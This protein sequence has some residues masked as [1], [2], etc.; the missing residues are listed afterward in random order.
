MKIGMVQM[1]TQSKKEENLDCGVKM[2]DH[3]AKQKVDLVVFPEF[4]NFLGPEK[5]MVKQGEVLENSPSLQQMAD[6]ARQHKLHVHIGSILERS[7]E[8]SYNTSVVLSPE[9][10]ILAQYRKIHLFDVEIPGGRRYLESDIITPGEEV[11]TF[12]IQG[13]TF[14]M[15]TCYDL[16]F[17]EMFRKLVELG[18]QVF[19]LP[20]AFTMET[21]RDHWELLLRARAVENLCWVVGVN[22]WGKFEPNHNSYGRSMAVDPWGVVVCRA[23]D[24]VQSL[25]VEID[26]ELLRG[27]RERFP[28]LD[29]IRREI[30]T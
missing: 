5:E 26:L 12:E 18:A 6:A 13:V 24:G 23:S 19:L 15:A 11:R 10:E 4:F 7:G 30:F 1:N 22:Q 16:R 21:G 17:P 9:G 20:A 8:E 3:L 28:A 25:T 27:I 14:G 2:I 29:H